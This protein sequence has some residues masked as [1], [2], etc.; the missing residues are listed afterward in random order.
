MRRVAQLIFPWLAGAFSACCLW[1]GV[2]ISLHQLSYA[3]LSATVSFACAALFG[4]AALAVWRNWVIRRAIA[5]CAGAILVLYALSVV[6]LG[7]EDVGGA[8]VAIPLSLLTASVGI[9]G[10]LASKKST[11]RAAA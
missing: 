1:E 11:S 7:W 8:V 5:I 6:F 10:M 2:D 4:I 9:L 3:S